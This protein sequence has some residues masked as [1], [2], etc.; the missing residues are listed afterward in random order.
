MERISL[1][2]AT[3]AAPPSK[4][5]PITPSHRHRNHA[6]TLVKTRHFPPPGKIFSKKP[7]LRNEAKENFSSEIEKG[8]LMTQFQKL[9]N[10]NC[11]IQTD[12]TNLVLCE[13]N[14]FLSPRSQPVKDCP[15]KCKTAFMQQWEQLTKAQS[16]LKIAAPAMKKVPAVPLSALCRKPEIRMQTTKPVPAALKKPLP[17]VKEESTIDELSEIPTAAFPA[18]NQKNADS[19]PVP[20]EIAP[21]PTRRQERN[22]AKRKVLRDILAKLDKLKKMKQK[23]AVPA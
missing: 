5:A 21:Q 16:E 14:V 13:H 10:E 12:I 18:E 8:K 9:V 17:V 4:S 1:E 20:S 22:A 15:D 2:A 19:N 11:N 7:A 23:N 3:F 6:G